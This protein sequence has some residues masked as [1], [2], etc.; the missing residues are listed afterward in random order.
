MLLR[1]KLIIKIFLN[2]RIYSNIKKIKDKNN[3][4]LKNDQ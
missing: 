3:I 2:I 1:Y 4:A